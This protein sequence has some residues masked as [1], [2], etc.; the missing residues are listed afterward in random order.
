MLALLFA[1]QAF[2]APELILSEQSYRLRIPSGQNQLELPR[3]ESGIRKPQATHPWQLRRR[4][5]RLL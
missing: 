5:A 3:K 4:Q 2:A 1:D